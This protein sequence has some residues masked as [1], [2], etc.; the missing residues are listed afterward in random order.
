MAG[1]LYHFGPIGEARLRVRESRDIP[2][3]EK[4]P[5]RITRHT[6]EIR[7]T[8]A[9]VPQ[10]RVENVSRHRNQQVGRVPRNEMC[11]QRQGHTSGTGTTMEY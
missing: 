4:A 10:F 11:C 3:D 7:E 6:G 1:Q 9:N 8:V 2:Q 5:E